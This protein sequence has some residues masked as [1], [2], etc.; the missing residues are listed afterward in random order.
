MCLQEDAVIADFGLDSRMLQCNFYGGTVIIT[1]KER[2][3]LIYTNHWER[4]RRT[5]SAADHSIT[6]RHR[7]YRQNLRRIYVETSE[8]SNE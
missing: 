1:A 3:E 4:Q 6:A 8:A 2:M 7:N 5:Y